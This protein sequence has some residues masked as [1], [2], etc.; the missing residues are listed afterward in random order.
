MIPDYLQRHKQFR[1]EVCSPS[2]LSW[3]ILKRW[4]K[5]LGDAHAVMKAIPHPSSPPA[6]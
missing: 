4:P 6:S 5:K 2:I 1:H 3:L